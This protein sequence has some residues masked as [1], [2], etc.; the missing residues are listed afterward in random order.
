MENLN[1]EQVKKALDCCTSYCDK[2]NCP[3]KTHDFPIACMTM[4]M[5]DA[6]ALINS[7]EQRI[8]E[9]AEEINGWQELVRVAVGTQNS[10]GERIEKLT[11]ENERLK[12]EQDVRGT[13]NKYLMFKNEDLQKANK[14]LGEYCIELQDELNTCIDIKADTIKK[15][16]D[17]IRSRATRNAYSCMISGDIRETYTISG[18]ALEEIEKE[19]LEDV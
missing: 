4:R 15:T 2:D 18:K 9:L 7:Q 17:A 8:K 5:V 1:A 16:L 11:E 6:L 12:G 10:M 14:D 19:L 13:L 3:Y